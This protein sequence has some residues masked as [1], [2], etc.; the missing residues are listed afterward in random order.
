MRPGKE[1]LKTIKLVFL[2]QADNNARM[3]G[4]GMIQRKRQESS[5]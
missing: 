2:E 5:S 1:L 3:Q 4:I